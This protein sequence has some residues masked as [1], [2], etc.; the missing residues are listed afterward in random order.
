MHVVRVGTEDR[1][2]G[3]SPHPENTDPFDWLEL[4]PSLDSHDR[5]LNVNTVLVRN[6][7]STHCILQR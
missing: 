7:P 3:V 1:R 4:Q 5:T 6:E 2:C